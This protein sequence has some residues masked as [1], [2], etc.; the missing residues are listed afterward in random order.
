MSDTPPDDF[1][2]LRLRL[3]D[4]QKTGMLDPRS[5]GTYQQTIF[6]V[7][8][9]TVRR[10]ESCFAQAATL[11]QQ[12]AAAE[13]QGHAFSTMGSIL[14]SVVNGYVDLEDRRVAEELGRQAVRDGT[15]PTHSATGEA[16]EAATVEAPE[17]APQV[18]PL[19]PR[20]SIVTKPHRKKP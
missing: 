2:R 20:A 14:H 12:A 7:L 1:T 9:E 18:A 15:A 16:Y 10:K 6:Q 19:D 3:L 8:Q 4:L 11:R 13:A 17:A 5:F